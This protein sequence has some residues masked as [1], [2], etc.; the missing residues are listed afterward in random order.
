MT[1]SRRAALPAKTTHPMENLLSPEPG[2]DPE[3]AAA[4]QSR[5]TAGEVAP[6]ALSSSGS[7]SPAEVQ[8]NVRIDRDVS[9]AFDRALLTLAAARGRKVTKKAGIEEAIQLFLHEHNL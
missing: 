1:T 2:P 8:L 4:L 5:P 6:L 9:Q 7:G 3:P